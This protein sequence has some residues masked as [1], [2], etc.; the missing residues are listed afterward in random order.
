M[1]QVVHYVSKVRGTAETREF[2]NEFL[3]PTERLQMGKRLTAVIM[4]IKGYSFTQIEEALKL[5][6]ATVVKLWQSLKENKF[7]RIRSLATWKGRPIRE[8]TMFEDFLNL[9]TE[10]LP[11][12]AGKGRYRYLKGL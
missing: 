4:L 10:G 11:P 5:S 7:T 9:L 3:T 1:E 12:R 8:R 6:P 2:I